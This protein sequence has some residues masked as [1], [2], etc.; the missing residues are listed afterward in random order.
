MEL[1]KKRR[2]NRESIRGKVGIF[3]VETARTEEGERGRS[4][5]GGVESNDDDWQRKKESRHVKNMYKL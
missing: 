5:R 4:G 3:R 2:T 1:K